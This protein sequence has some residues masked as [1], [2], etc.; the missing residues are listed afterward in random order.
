MRN[1][2]GRRR[3][4]FFFPLFILMALFAF[5]FVVYWLWNRVLVAV[6]PV[7]AVTYWQAMGLLIL[8][9][10]LL[11]GF[12]GGPPGGRSFEG[13]RALARKVASNERGRSSEIQ[14]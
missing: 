13:G 6:V 7:K 10:I 11:G 14:K 9:R 3:I 2:A 8:S 5:S 12:K 4:R 1:Y